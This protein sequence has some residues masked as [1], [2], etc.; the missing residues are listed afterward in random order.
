MEIILQCEFD[1]FVKVLQEEFVLREGQSACLS[2]I[3]QRQIVFLVYPIKQKLLL[4]YTVVLEIENNKP[5][6]QS[7]NAQIF[8]VGEGGFEMLLKKNKLK[9]LLEGEIHTANVE[10]F[11]VI[12]FEGSPNLLCVKNSQGANF[13]EF[14][15]R[16]DNIAFE[17]KNSSPFLLASNGSSKFLCAFCASS[18]SF[19]AYEAQTVKVLENKI[20]VTV[21]VLGQAK[22]GRFVVLNF[23]NAGRVE[24]EEDDLIYFE[25]E[26]VLASNLSVI[27]FAFFQSVK[28][29]DF[30]LAKAYLS[31]QL[32]EQI[33]PDMLR[34][35]FGD[36]ERVSPYNFHQ[37]YGQYVCV[38]LNKSVKVFAFK[39]DEGKIS[40]I[41]LVKEYDKKG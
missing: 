22:H 23:E 12:V 32:S 24:V 39:F 1:C 19:F 35:Y 16:I 18:K 20:E 40:D 6:T 17:G 21:K 7:P 9:K 14:E 30:E 36:F 26:P 38:F 25:G 34:E 13:F 8:Q 33:S 29:G 2:E 4:P 3:N 41:T 15:F 27:P 5:L 11:E 28:I 10:G 37:K 31:S